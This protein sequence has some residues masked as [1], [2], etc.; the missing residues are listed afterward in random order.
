MY[1]YSIRHG[2]ATGDS[3]QPPASEEGKYRIRSLVVAAR[4][5]AGRQAAAAAARGRMRGDAVP[6][7]VTETGKW[8]RSRGE[9][10]EEFA[11]KL[12]AKF[13]ADSTAAP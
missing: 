11:K 5:S 9:S 2:S 12:A 4:A 1:S 10:R 8:A 6:V 13:Q 7:A 3:A